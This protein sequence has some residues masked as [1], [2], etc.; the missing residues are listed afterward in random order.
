MAEDERGER[1][2]ERGWAGLDSGVEDG[3]IHGRD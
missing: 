3:L 2:E 1:R